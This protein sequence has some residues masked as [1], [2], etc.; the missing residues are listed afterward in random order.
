[1]KIYAVV[2]A[3]RTHTEFKS[4]HVSKG[5]AELAAERLTATFPVRRAGE[6]PYS[7]IPINVED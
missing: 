3:T 7:V 1:M 6:T 4:F 5:K 2:R